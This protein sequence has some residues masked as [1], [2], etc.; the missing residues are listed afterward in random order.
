[1]GSM[2]DYLSQ[3]AIWVPPATCWLWDRAVD[4]GGYGVFSRKIPRSRR[5][6]MFRA[7]RVSYETFVGP[8]APGLDV[9]HRCDTPCCINPDHLFLGTRLENMADMKSKGRQ[10]N[11]VQR[12][13]R[14]GSAKLT[15]TEVAEIRRL[16]RETRLSQCAIGERFGVSGTQVSVIVRGLSW[17]ET[18]EP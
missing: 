14:N 2:A 10:R 6:V 4:L 9:C 16:R 5:G 17:V 12:G 1:M 3:R 11:G 18:C 13:E 8:I 7:H 15:P